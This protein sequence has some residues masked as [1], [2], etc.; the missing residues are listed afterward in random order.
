MTAMTPRLSILLPTYN[1]AA[2]LARFLET[3]HESIRR[4]A[5]DPRLVEFVITDNASWDDTSEVIAHFALKS[6]SPVISLRNETNLGPVKNVMSGL[7]QTTGDWIFVCGD[8]DELHPEGIGRIFKGMDLYKD[9]GLIC[10]WSTGTSKS[11]G[12]SE[13]TAFTLEELAS[14]Y[15]YFPGNCGF[16]IGWGE[17]ARET[18]RRFAKSGIS[19]SP[20]VIMDLLAGS[21]A[22]RGG[23]KPAI[24]TPEIVSSNP[25]HGSNTVYT[26]YYLFGITIMGLIRS[27]MNV[28]HVFGLKLAPL[29]ARKQLGGLETLRKI[30]WL[31]PRAHLLADL[32][33]DANETKEAAWRGLL[34]APWVAKPFCLSVLILLSLP[35]F[36]KWG[37]AALLL[38]ITERRSW[39]K[40]YIRLR[41]EAVEVKAL[42]I[43]KA[44][45]GGVGIYTKKDM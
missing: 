1:R 9:A 42:R 12:V 5:G 33:S 14:T 26:S 30:K 45:A 41:N 44:A 25:N 29:V 39:L 6:S 24:M 21:C 40:A 19:A 8:D 35:G 2:L 31:F 3:A 13:V 17:G 27:A 4:W 34:E 28:D 22:I 16:A 43:R 36:I 23:S 15:W 10:F 32:K 18:A 38:M 20:W 7:A 37:G 11:D